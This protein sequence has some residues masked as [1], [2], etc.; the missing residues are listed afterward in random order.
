MNGVIVRDRTA[1]TCKKTASFPNGVYDDR[2]HGMEDIVDGRGAVLLHTTEG[3]NSEGYLRCGNGVSIHK[4]MQRDGQIIKMVNEW[5][6]A[7]HAGRSSFGGRSDWNNF[8]IGYE[9]EHKHGTNQITDIQ[10]EAVAQ[11]IAYDTARFHIFD[12]WVR[13][14]REVALPRGRKL[15]PTDY[16]AERVWRRVMQIRMNWPAEW[17]IPLWYRPD[18]DLVPALRL[19]PVIRTDSLLIAA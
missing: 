9:I 4:L 13:F 19:L 2:P 3:Y 5:E 7:F 16:D 10:Y 8:S 12:Y 11:S 1:L 14:H 17:G 15:D 18:A 6:R